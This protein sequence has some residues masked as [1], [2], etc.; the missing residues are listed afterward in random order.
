MVT[1]RSGECRTCRKQMTVKGT[2]LNQMFINELFRI[3]A[4]IHWFAKHAKIGEGMLAETMWLVVDLTIIP[5]KVIATI[6]F[7]AVW[8][9]TYPFWVLHE[10][11]S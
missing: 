11:L 2:L 8:F 9:A 7:F 10:F 5:F 1:E 6:I 3:K 4:R